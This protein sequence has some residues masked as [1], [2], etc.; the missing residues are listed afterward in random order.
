MTG[1][2]FGYTPR[3]R[4]VAEPPFWTLCDG[5]A[6]GRVAVAQGVPQRDGSA[7]LRWLDQLD[8]SRIWWRVADVEWRLEA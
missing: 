7:L 4:S 8:T 3:G 5:G 1:V 6:Y 2:A